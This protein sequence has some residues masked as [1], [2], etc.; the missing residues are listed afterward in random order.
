MSADGERVEGE[1][2]QSSELRVGKI[3]EVGEY[4]GCQEIQRAA[5]GLKEDG[6][7]VPVATLAA[8]NK[9][10]GL[11]LGARRGE[12]LVGFSF[13]FLGRVQ[14]ELV[15]YSQLTAVLPE[16]Q[17]GGAG[18]A[19][20]QGQ[21]E[22]AWEQGLGKIVWAFDPMQ[23]GNANFNLHK[24]GAFCR[25]YEVNMYGERSD[26]L[27]SGLG[28][29]DR[30]IAEWEVAGVVRDRP[31]LEECR[32]V[33]ETEWDEEGQIRRAVELDL[34][35]RGDGAVSI[36]IPANVRRL[37]AVSPAEAQKWQELARTAF[38][39][40]FEAGYRAVDFVRREDEGGEKRGWYLLVK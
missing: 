10:G 4:R 21:Q 20:K 26:A 29:T 22:W 23:G 24:L 37:A 6:Y 18:L 31:K 17:G 8:V 30:L 35:G 2:T 40:L 1:N 19:L 12:R 5:W 9:Y 38:Q 39:Q 25:T 27:N 28:A 15:L 33:L 3:G 32:P 7:V 11:V 14:G 16:E 34:A 36:E 13:G